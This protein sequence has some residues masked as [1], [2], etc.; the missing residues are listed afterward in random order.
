MK[1]N[2]GSTRERFYMNGGRMKEVMKSKTV[3]TLDNIVIQLQA[4]QFLWLQNI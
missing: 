1:E 4:V 3:T 2:I